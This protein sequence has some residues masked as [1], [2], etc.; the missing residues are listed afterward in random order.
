MQQA[1]GKSLPNLLLELSLYI[2]PWEKTLE[3]SL[4]TFIAIQAL[5][6]QWTG[7]PLTQNE[8][9]KIGAVTTMALA[10]LSAIVH[11]LGKVLGDKVSLEAY[12][13]ILWIVQTTVAKLRDLIR[14]VPPLSR[15]I[16]REAV[17]RALIPLVESGQRIWS[18]GYGVDTLGAAQA[19]TPEACDAIWEQWCRRSSLRQQIMIG[20]RIYFQMLFLIQKSRG[21]LSHA[22]ML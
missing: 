7:Q 8:N 12:D 11:W 4:A 1:L 16:D 5:S 13:W 18:T 22:V 17:G 6:H 19:S 9:L 2:Y 15:V 14:R 21:V 20:W 3:A 10:T